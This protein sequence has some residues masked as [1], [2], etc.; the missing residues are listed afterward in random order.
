MKGYHDSMVS[1]MQEGGFSGI[2]GDFSSTCSTP[3]LFDEPVELCDE[4]VSL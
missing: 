4:T 2:L 1:G 3:A